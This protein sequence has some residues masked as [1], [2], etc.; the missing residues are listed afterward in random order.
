[1]VL[2]V[3]L[4]LVLKLIY[5][6]GNFEIKTPQKI[7]KSKL[8]FFGFLFNIPPHFGNFPK[9]FYVF[10]RAF[11]YKIIRSIPDFHFVK[12]SG[13]S[14]VLNFISKQKQKSRIIQIFLFLLQKLKMFNTNIESTQ[15]LI[16]RNRH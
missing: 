2:F 9:F 5:K 7:L 10:F 3:F 15:Y 8:D 11:L 1:M 14:G 4:R 13:K 16:A 6:T 12:Q